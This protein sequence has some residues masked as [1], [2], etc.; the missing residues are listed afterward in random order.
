MELEAAIDAHAA[1]LATY[2]GLP[3]LR[4]M[5]ALEAALGRPMNIAA[6]Q[7]D[8]GVFLLAA[9]YGHGIAN[10]HPFVDG[11]KRAAFVESTGFLEVNG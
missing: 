9:A 11:N 2:G 8:A 10:N 1:Q 3:G 4:D 5:G 7:P 6:H